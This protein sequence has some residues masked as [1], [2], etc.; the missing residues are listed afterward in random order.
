[1]N[2]EMESRFGWIRILNL[3]FVIAQI[4]DTFFSKEVIYTF[5][6]ESIIAYLLS[7]IFACTQQ[8]PNSHMIGDWS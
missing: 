4:I 5:F 7:L 8:T 2:Q 6:I 1:M 3:I